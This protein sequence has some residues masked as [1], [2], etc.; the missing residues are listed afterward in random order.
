MWNS[1]TPMRAN[2]LIWA[3]VGSAVPAL[4]MGL[5]F[6]LPDLNQVRIHDEHGYLLQADTF[7][8]GRMSN[9][10]PQHPEFFESPYILVSPTYQAKYPPAQAAFLARMRLAVV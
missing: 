5:V 4:Y 3:V 9:P 1:K 6:G 10:A 7:A 2:L 8:S